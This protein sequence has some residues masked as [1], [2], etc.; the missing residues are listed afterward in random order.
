M[1]GDDQGEPR[2]RQRVGAY[3]I[4]REGERIL[5]CRLSERVVSAGRWTLPGG[6]IDFGEHPADAVVREIEEETGL[7]TEVV[8]LLAVDSF[9]ADRVS[10]DGPISHHGLRIV[11]EMQ[12]TGGQ[13]RHEADEST[14]QACWFTEDEARSLPL[15]E[16]AE[17]ALDLAFR[18]DRPHRLR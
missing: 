17:L 3:G 16:L 8:R 10:D 13:L 18:D 4:I 14:D 12:V 2:R 7:H 15:F 11:Y 9:V 6:G 5:L 1:T